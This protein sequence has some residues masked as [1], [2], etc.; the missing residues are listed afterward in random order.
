MRIVAIVQARMGSSRLPG[1]ALRDI[2]GRTMLARVV[3]RAKRSALIDRLVVATT[4]NYADNAIVSECES[5]GV[6]SF[7]GSEDDVLDRY[8]QAARAFHANCIVRITSDCP[9]IDPEIID[10]VVQAFLDGGPDYASNTII[11]TYPRGLDVEV[12]S[13]EALEEAWHNA[14]RDFEH[15]HVT[16]YIYQHPELFHKLAVTGEKDWSRYRWTVDTKEDLD[17]VRAIYAKMDRDDLFSWRAVL[18]LFEREP[19]L[20]DINRHIRQKSLEEC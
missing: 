10:S 9:L 13:F 18:E 11:S 1:K 12:F 7:R 4:E 17:L 3:R 6:S 8:Y 14:S 2:L 16:P 15:V 19:D 20:A 5:L